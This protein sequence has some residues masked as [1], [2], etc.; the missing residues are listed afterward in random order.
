MTFP[1]S[2]RFR[3]SDRVAC[4]VYDGSAE[5]ITLDEPIRQ[6][7]L[8]RV[9]TC[10]WEMAERGVTL[11]EIARGVSTR[12]AVEPGQARDDARAFVE[13]LVAKKMLVVEKGP[14]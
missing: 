13:E 3:Q 12:F 1:E 7:Q 10:I 8:N 11:D 9:G 4:R 2:T 6:H 14:V 5:V